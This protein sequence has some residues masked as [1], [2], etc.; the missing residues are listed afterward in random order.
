MPSTSKTQAL[1]LRDHGQLGV[2]GALALRPVEL[3]HKVGAGATLVD[4]LVME[5]LQMHKIAKVKL[6]LC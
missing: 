3:G 4:F 6:S 5:V 1:Q 2:P